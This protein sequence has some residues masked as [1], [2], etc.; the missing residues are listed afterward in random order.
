[1]YIQ[2]FFPASFNT[3]L[4]ARSAS[5]RYSM[6]LFVFSLAIVIN[7]WNSKETLRTPCVYLKGEFIYLETLARWIIDGHNATGNLRERVNSRRWKIGCRSSFI[8]SLLIFPPTPSPARRPLVRVAP[9]RGQRSFVAWF[10]LPFIGILAA[11]EL[12]QRLKIER[13]FSAESFTSFSP[14]LHISSRLIS[15]SFLLR[16]AK[17][18]KINQRLIIA[19]YIAALSIFHPL[20]C[21]RRERIKAERRPRSWR[22]DFRFKDQCLPLG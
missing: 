2:V 20:R 17:C 22:R 18:Q 12:R 1:M 6:F 15:C 13:A 9:R 8:A 3:P 5:I 16:G 10:N 14:P 7:F 4:V 21:K 11:S 19:L